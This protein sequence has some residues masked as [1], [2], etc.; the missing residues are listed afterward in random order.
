[1]SV[2]TSG[3]SKLLVNLLRTSLRC[4]FLIRSSAKPIR[5]GSNIK[6]S[7]ELPGRKRDLGQLLFTIW[8]GRISELSRLIYV[9]AGNEIDCDQQ[10]GV[11]NGFLQ[12]IGLKEHWFYNSEHVQ[13]AIIRSMPCRGEIF[14]SSGFQGYAGKSF[15][16]G[17]YFG[18]GVV[19]LAFRRQRAPRF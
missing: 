13:C 1:M 3:L 4:E 14:F 7:V 17:F 9:K 15:E 5:P 16:L 6:T 19:S 12:K 18:H 8:P 10:T 2:S 11:R